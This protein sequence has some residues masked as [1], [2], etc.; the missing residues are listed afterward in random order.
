[1]RG[2]P[3]ASTISD[4]T[5]ANGAGVDT[6]AASGGWKPLRISDP[7]P[8]ASAPSRRL[9]TSSAPVGFAV[10]R[11]PLRSIAADVAAPADASVRALT[12]TL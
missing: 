12:A 1:V 9:A 6:D 2:V 11:R 4:A 3:V 10:R 8:S 5:L 7:P